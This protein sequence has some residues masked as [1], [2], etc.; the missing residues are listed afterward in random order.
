MDSKLIDEFEHEHRKL[1]TAIAGLTR[2]QMKAFP[3]PGTWSIQQIVLH[4]VDSAIIGTDRMHRIIAMDNPMIQAYDET[5]FTKNLHYHE[6]S[7]EDALAMLE[8]NG[9]Q[10]ARLLRCLPPE[11]FSRSGIHLEAGKIT[12][13][14]M[15]RRNVMHVDHHLKFIEKKKGMVLQHR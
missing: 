15:L 13:E 8:L 6:Q 4:V 7:V 11:A 3:I 12:L 5:Q 9:R 2:E 1:R 10:A 14:E